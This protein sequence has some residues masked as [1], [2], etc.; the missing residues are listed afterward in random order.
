MRASNRVILNTVAQYIRIIVNMVLSLYTV[1]LVLSTLG[2]NDFGIYSL[3]AGVVAMLAF[4]TNS[5]VVTTQRFVSFYQGK[6]KIEKTKEIFN[7]S[8]AIHIIIGLVVSAILALF[9]PFLFNGFLNI[10]V[11][12]IETGKLVYYTVVAIIFVSFITAPYRALLI[13][14]EN[15]VYIS[16]VDIIDAVLKVILVILMTF[17]DND[18]LM[19]YSFIMLFINIVTFLLLMIYDYSKYTECVIP[20]FCRLKLSYVMEM[21]TFAG[22]SVYQTGCVVG[23]QQGISI[24]LNRFM[25]P[26]VN[27]AYGIGFQIAGY[28]NY[29]AGAVANAISPQIVKAEGSGDRE[30]ALWLSKVACKFNF[31]LLSALCVPCMFEIDNIL[32]LWLGTVPKDSNV[33]SIMVMLTLLCDAISIGFKYLVQAMGRLGMYSIIT[34]T[35][36]LLALPIAF[37]IVRNNFP[38]E[39]VVIAYVT[40]ELIC[41][42]L[43]IPY[44]YSRGRLQMGDF[45]KD[46]MLKEIFV[47]TVLIIVCWLITSFFDCQYRFLLTFGFGLTIHFITIYVIGLTSHEKLI[48][49][50]VIRS[51]IN[52]I[53][54]N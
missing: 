53:K 32:K 12:R 11:D 31:F 2:E 10:P 18:K 1:R 22:W 7:N 49:N 25:G 15:I 35:P 50:K 20:N 36:K 40:V 17:L 47:T 23:R 28:T 44:L 21:G 8:L 27:A 42:L 5:L 52:K 54:K 43:R 16:V 34:A 33:F 26:V 24:V 51:I 4:V 41:S 30:K 19:L 6:G 45:F 37:F 3:I 29:L 38:I 48:V 14:H 13:S 9:T 46:V 39:W